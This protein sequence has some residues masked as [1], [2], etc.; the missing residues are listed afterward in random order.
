MPNMN[1]ILTFNEYIKESAKFDNEHVAV[2]FN[3][4]EIK[5]LRSKFKHVT[6][7]YPEYPEY[8]VIKINFNYTVSKT[9]DYYRIHFINIICSTIQSLVKIVSKLYDYCKKYTS[10]ILNDIFTNINLKE[11]SINEEFLYFNYN[12]TVM[13]VADRN[14]KVIKINKSIVNAS[15]NNNKVIIDQIKPY[16]EEKY[17]LIGYQ[18][19]IF[20]DNVNATK[21]V[22]N[23]F[24]EKYPLNLD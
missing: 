24:A 22:T 13:I 20:Q 11:D 14:K 17:N 7:L 21:K 4:N 12:N 6:N 1:N 23:Y 16:I 9:E 19:K 5:Y 8:K 15:Y 18:Y 3:N 2:P 10:I